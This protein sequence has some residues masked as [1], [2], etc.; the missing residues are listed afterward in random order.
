MK[1]KELYLFIDLFQELNLIYQV[2]QS[3]L[4]LYLSYES[5]ISI[6]TH[7]QHR[8]RNV[9]LNIRVILHFCVLSLLQANVHFNRETQWKIAT[10]V[11]TFLMSTKLFSL[12]VRLLISSSYLESKEV[13]LYLHLN[14][15]SIAKLLISVLRSI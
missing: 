6:L 12:S 5:F 2:V 14:L 1:T 11:H 4:Q 8:K 13:E 15:A 10:E 7:T 3:S 9:F